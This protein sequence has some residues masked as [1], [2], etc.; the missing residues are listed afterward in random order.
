MMK[1]LHGRGR[2]IVAGALVYALVLQGVVFAAE[3]VQAASGAAPGAAGFELCTHAG[4]DAVLP[5]T[6]AQAPLGANH[7]PFCLAGLAL[8]VNSTPPCAAHDGRPS[9]SIA[10]WPPMAPQLVALIIN[11]SARPRGPPSAA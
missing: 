7:C 8:Y 2:R 11:E 9:F 6:P 4:G 1:F 3:I 5:D 10:A